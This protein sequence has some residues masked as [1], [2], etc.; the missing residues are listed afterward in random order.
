[1]DK[2]IIEYWIAAY[3]KTGRIA[4][5]HPRKNTMSL[6]GGR[7]IPVTGAIRRIKECLERAKEK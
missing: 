4:F 2:K 1:M 7:P 6:N 3:E 5:Y